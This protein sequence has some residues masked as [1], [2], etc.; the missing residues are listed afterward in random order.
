MP[1]R[2]DIFHLRIERRILK[3]SW[4]CPANHRISNRIRFPFKHWMTS[5][6]EQSILHTSTDTPAITYGSISPLQSAG[7][8]T[9]SVSPTKWRNYKLSRQAI[10][11]VPGY[12]SQSSVKQMMVNISTFPRERILSVQWKM[13]PLDLSSQVESAESSIQD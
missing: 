1:K 5:K 9:S 11:S 2:I 6:P 13:S 8:C 10:R 12:L 3:Q 7:E 4:S